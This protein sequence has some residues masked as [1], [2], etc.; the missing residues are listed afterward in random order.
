M[1]LLA[2]ECIETSIIEGLRKKGFEVDAVSEINPGT[3]DTSIIQLANESR[4]ILLTA[5]KDFGELIFRQG[6]VTHEIILIRL[7]G[8]SRIKKTAIL[9]NAL[10]E[11]QDKLIGSFSVIEPTQVRI[12]RPKK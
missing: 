1:R 3:S 7:H 5:D 12:T 4:A 9:A 6:R 2:D 10:K 11:H 8:L